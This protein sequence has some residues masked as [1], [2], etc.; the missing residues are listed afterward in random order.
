MAHHVAGLI[1]EAEHARG[2]AR[3]VAEDRC[4]AAVLEL[5]SYRR[6]LEGRRPTNELEPILDML[7]TMKAGNGRRYF[8]RGVWERRD[9]NSGD[10]SPETV[11][12]L[13]LAHNADEAARELIGWALGNAAAAAVDSSLEWIGLARKAGAGDDDL[14]RITLRFRSLLP[15]SSADDE[16]PV[17]PIEQRL[18][19]LKSARK[20]L[21]RLEKELQTALEEL[22]T[23]AQP[24]A[25]APKRKRP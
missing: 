7:E 13:D 23:S 25:G 21:S 9:E 8:H 1:D 16:A 22:R 5:W 15:E 4:R 12:W 20:T 14:V 19:R 10:E 18:E 24:V 3:A 6:S 2:K 17:D 11:K